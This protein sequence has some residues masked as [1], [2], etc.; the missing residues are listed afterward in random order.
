VYELVLVFRSSGKWRRIS[1]VAGAA[2]SQGHDELVCGACSCVRCS[3]GDQGRE[4]RGGSEM[5]AI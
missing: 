2:I 3:K 1:L 4:D 5:G